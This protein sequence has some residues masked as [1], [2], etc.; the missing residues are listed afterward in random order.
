MHQH[1][2]DG[3]FSENE[4]FHR[5]VAWTILGLSPLVA[6]LLMGWKPATY[7]KLNANASQQRNWFGPK[8]PAKWCWMIF[9]SPNW[10]WVLYSLYDFGS[11][12]PLPYLLLLLW[13]LLHYLY[14]SILYPLCMSKDSTFP[15][16]I[17]AFTVPYCVTNGY[18]Q[19]QGLLKFQTFP[20]GYQYSPVFVFGLL[21]GIGGFVIGFISDQ[22]L[23]QLRK[24]SHEQIMDDNK[25]KTNYFVPR[26]GLFEYVTCPHFLGEILEWMGFCIACQGSLASLSFVIWTACNLIPRALAQHQW[27]HL[28]FGSEYPATRKAIVPFLL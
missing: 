11:L 27:Y 12:P 21:L 4:E 7:G 18:L 19:T 26:G 16:G 8:L 13:F 14:R 23:L 6:L 10:I 25:K 1:H 17:L 28:Q 22:T 3:A 15:I 24:Q 9:E 20:S 5:S 2:R